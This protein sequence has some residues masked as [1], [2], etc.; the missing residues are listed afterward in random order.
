[1]STTTAQR[2]WESFWT[3]RINA[4]SLKVAY[5]E[6]IRHRDSPLQVEH[7]GGF[8]GE[9]RG[10]GDGAGSDVEPGG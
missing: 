6:V 8:A 4:L 3:R 9:G 2:T 10:D 7:G 5:F 1:M